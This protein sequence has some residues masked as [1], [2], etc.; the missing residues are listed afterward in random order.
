[1]LAIETVEAG[2][3]EPNTEVARRIMEEARAAGLLIGKGGLYGNVLRIA[4][5]MTV[6]EAEIDEAA[7]VLVRI[8]EGLG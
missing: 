6:T 5:P 4:P 8:I 3:L 1:M 7:D 2:T